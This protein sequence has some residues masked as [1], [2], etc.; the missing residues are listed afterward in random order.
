MDYNAR[1]E[2]SFRNAC[3]FQFR[4]A[5]VGSFAALRM[6]PKRAVITNQKLETF[7]LP[8]SRF[9]Q[10]PDLAPDQVAL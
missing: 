1:G 9:L 2:C 3:I 7:S 4:A 5:L 6:T 8:L 10:F